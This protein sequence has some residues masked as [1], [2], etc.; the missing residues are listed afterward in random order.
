MFT[1]RDVL[2]C[3]NQSAFD[4]SQETVVHLYRPYTHKHHH[5]Q[6]TSPNQHKHTT[7]FKPDGE[8]KNIRK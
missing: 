3:E 5:D 8:G 6:A 2:L 7:V 4:Y 1:Q